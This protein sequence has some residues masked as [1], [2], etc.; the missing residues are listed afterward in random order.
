MSEKRDRTGEARF[1]VTVE[2]VTYWIDQEQ[3]SR[4]WYAYYYE[5]GARKTRRRSLRT[6]DREDAKVE[7]MVFVLRR[8]SNEPESPDNI[9]WAQVMNYYN[10]NYVGKGLNYYS[11]KRATE[12]ILEFLGN[13]APVSCFTKSKQNEYLKF[14]HQKKGLSVGTINRYLSA[15]VAALNMVLRDSHDKELEN[16]PRLTHGVHIYYTKPH[17]AKVLNVAEPGEEEVWLPSYSELGQFIDAIKTEALFRYVIVALN[18]WARPEAITDLT[19]FQ[20]D[21]E[22]EVIRLN[23]GDRRQTKKY[24]PL[25]R[26][27]N[28]LD[29]WLDEWTTDFLISIGNE[30]HDRKV[31]SVRSAFETNRARVDLPKLTRYSLRHFMATEAASHGV[32]LEQREIWM[33]HKRVSM[34]HTYTHFEPNYLAEAKQATEAVITK[35]QEYTNRELLHPK[36]TQKSHFGFSKNKTGA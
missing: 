32:P 1:E 8:G 28:T 12:L 6:E 3:R 19:R 2:G 26:L 24:R 18:T 5:P 13:D 15:N 11:S 17:I 29:P 36:R 4:S 30:K 33:G 34:T 10:E 21:R 9:L 7:L 27:P 14:L 23:P 16:V 20:I 35:L 25:I 31:R 22:R